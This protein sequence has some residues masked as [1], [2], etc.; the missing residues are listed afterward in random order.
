MRWLTI[1]NTAEYR[2]LFTDRVQELLVKKEAKVVVTGPYGFVARLANGV[3]ISVTQ[4]SFALGFPMFHTRCVD[5]NHEELSVNADCACLCHT[6][7]PLHSFA[8]VSKT[9]PAGCHCLFCAEPGIRPTNDPPCHICGK[10]KGQPPNRCPGH[11]DFPH[12]STAA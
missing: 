11:Y 7:N 8:K 1:P 2:K 3:E 5:C 10:A 9:H 12:S 6:R 4:D